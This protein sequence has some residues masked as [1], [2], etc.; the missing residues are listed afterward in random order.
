[1][2]TFF[3]SIK[4]GQ[5]KTT[6]AVGYAKHSDAVLITNDLDNGTIDIY[7]PALGAGRIVTLDP[8]QSLAALVKKYKGRDLV[9]DF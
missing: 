4:G 3:Y 8:G 6:H 9:L 1:M 7:E 5:G 2:K